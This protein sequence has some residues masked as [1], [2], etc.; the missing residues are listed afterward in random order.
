MRLCTAATAGH[1]HQC[2]TARVC[3]RASL[4]RGSDDRH[5]RGPAAA[6]SAAGCRSFGLHSEAQRAVDG[7]HRGAAGVDGVDDLGVVDA[8]EVDRGDAEV[9][10]PA[11]RATRRSSVRAAAAAQGR[12][13]V[14]P[15]TTQDSGPTGSETRAWSQGRCGIRRPRRG[16]VRAAAPCRRPPSLARHAAGIPRR[17][18]AAQQGDALPADPPTIEEIVTVMRQAGDSVHGWRLRGLIVVLWRAGLRIHE[19]LALVEVD[20]DPRRGLLLVRRGKGGRRREVGMD[21]WA[22]E[23]LERNRARW[24]DRPTRPCR[25]TRRQLQHRQPQRSRNLNRRRHSR[26]AGRFSSHRTRRANPGL[27]A[28]QRGRATSQH[29]APAPARRQSGSRERAPVDTRTL[30]WTTTPESTARPGGRGVVV[31]FRCFRPVAGLCH[32]ESRAGGSADPFRVCSGPAVFAPGGPGGCGL[33]RER[34][35]GSAG[36]GECSNA[37]ERV[38]RSSC[39]GQRAGSRSVQRPACLVRRPG[40]M[41][42]RRRTVRAVRTVEAGSPIKPVQRSRLCARQAITVHAPLALNWP[43]GKCA[44]GDAHL[45]GAIRCSAENVHC[46]GDDEDR[47]GVGDQR[48]DGHEALGPPRQRHC[49]CRADRDGVGERNVEIVA[50]S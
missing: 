20:L 4:S 44:N 14:A 21:D 29:R 37:R 6:D 11:W 36:R 12:P 40:S 32:L 48:L 28:R 39:Q 8:L 42:S 16:H 25:G 23:Q 22:W 43:E 49:V 9:G 17:K 41:S 26:N 2:A 50:Q 31:A 30:A 45:C 1:V 35:A 27:A 19:A 33:V 7:H 15:V 24:P 5:G 10:A 3:L 47:D 38:G 46:L 18:A 13:R 34:R